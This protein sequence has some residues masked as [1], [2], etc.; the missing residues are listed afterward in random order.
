MKKHV[1]RVQKG[2]GGGGAWS[3]G[4]LP[5]SR[6]VLPLSKKVSLVQKISIHYPHPLHRVSYM[7]IKMG[8]K[9]GK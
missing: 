8:S 5:F 9:P 2:V 6:M 3:T 7:Q 4:Y 1:R